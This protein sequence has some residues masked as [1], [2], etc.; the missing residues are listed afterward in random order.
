[1]GFHF[2]PSSTLSTQSNGWN[3][4]NENMRNYHGRCRDIEREGTKESQGCSQ[5]K[6]RQKA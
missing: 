4:S 2:S 3:H 1:M 5:G 6:S